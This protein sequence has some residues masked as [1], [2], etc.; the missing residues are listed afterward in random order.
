V[1]VCGN[2]ASVAWLA[3]W[4]LK[5]KQGGGDGDVGRT[6]GQLFNTVVLL[7]PVCGTQQ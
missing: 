4:L 5:W 3:Q 2:E 1:Q 6:G 7:G